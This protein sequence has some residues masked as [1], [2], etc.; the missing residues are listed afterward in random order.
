MLSFPEDGRFDLA[1]L[2]KQAQDWPGIEGMDLAKDVTTRQ[3][4]RWDETTWTI[5]EG[6]GRLTEP[7]F[8]VV[9]LRSAK[10]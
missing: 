6:Y 1:A 2:E 4:Y 3:S 7:K 5:G 8:R 9:A 10:A